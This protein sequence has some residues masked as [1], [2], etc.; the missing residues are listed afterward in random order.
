[1]NDNF[2]RLREPLE[3]LHPETRSQLIGNARRVHKKRLQTVTASFAVVALG[4][5]IQLRPV[6]DARAYAAE[7]MPISTYIDEEGNLATS[8]VDELSMFKSGT[9][10]QEIAIRLLEDVL[11]YDVV[12]VR[13][14]DLSTV[15]YESVELQTS[16]GQTFV[17]NFFV[18]GEMGYPKL[19]V[20]RL[21]KL[22]D[23]EFHD[24]LADEQMA[25]ARSGALIQHTSSI[26]V[27]TPQL[28]CEQENVSLKTW[29]AY[30]TQLQDKAQVENLLDRRITL[31]FSVQK[32][33]VGLAISACADVVRFVEPLAL[34][35]PGTY[36]SSIQISL[37]KDVTNFVAE[38][39]Y[40][41]SEYFFRFQRKFV[42]NND[43]HALIGAPK[44]MAKVYSGFAQLSP[45]DRCEHFSEEQN[46]TTKLELNT[47]K[48]VCGWSG[49]DIAQVILE[50][51]PGL[52]VELTNIW[53]EDASNRIL[54][55][56]W[57][58]IT[59][60]LKIDFR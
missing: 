1:M 40:S 13:A 49:D 21:Q 23:V 4:L 26:E 34:V 37:G 30:G 33:T 42:P 50:I 18:G 6:A 10:S 11:N 38:D 2:K 39:T 32:P 9:D 45:R 22:F 57:D 25:V 3:A 59:S 52:V 51:K 28:N 5:A 35:T 41:T 55:N 44:V 16:Q 54:P 27:Q 29:N 19:A 31:D 12:D 58:A 14:S 56:R 60:T 24:V 17:A 47:H 36:A 15:N 20:P 46:A 53:V 48:F 8:G 43:N 7:F